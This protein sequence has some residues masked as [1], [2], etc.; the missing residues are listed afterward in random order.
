MPNTPASHNLH[1]RMIKNQQNTK[2]MILEKL[3]IISY[4]GML[5]TQYYN[6]CMHHKFTKLFKQNLV[7]AQINLLLL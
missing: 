4:A 7:I 1:Y 6:Q 2:R 5:Y 3:F